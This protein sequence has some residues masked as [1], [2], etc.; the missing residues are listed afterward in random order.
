MANV[1]KIKKGLDINLVGRAPKVDVSTTM[2]SSFGV[3]PDDFHGIVPRL[4]VKVGDRVLAGSPVIYHK[5]IPELVLTSPV[6][7]EVVEVVRGAK[8]KIIAVEIKADQ[9]IEY[10]DFDVTGVTNRTREELLSLLLESGLFAL[11]KQRPYDIVADPTVMP[12]DIFV[13]ANYTAPLMPDAL[14]LIA[15]D[16]K[17]LQLAADVLRKL[18]SGGVYLGIK[19]GADLSLNGVNTYEVEGPHPA[20]NVGVLINHTRPINKGETV[21]T[22]SVSEMALIGRF[23]ATGKVDYRRRIVLAGSRLSTPGYTNVISGARI[24]DI[25]K[26]KL[27]SNPSNK[28]IIDGDV[29]TGTQVT[30]DHEYLSP[31]SNIITVIPEGDDVDELFGWAVPGFNKFSASRTYPSFLCKKREYNIDAR[32]RGGER[33]IIVSGEY[34]KVF[35]MDIYPEQLIK[36]IIAFDID[37]MEELGIYEVAPEDFALCEFVCT[38]KLELQYIV[39]RGLDLLYKEMN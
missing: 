18:T 35:P 6:S 16:K 29:L 36:S 31:F 17:Y 21:W 15:E 7:G 3:V 9:A 38:S 19:K 27:D 28:R 24:A 30:P 10:R 11:I 20:G 8:R 2:G 23:L 25:I 5:A 4:S 34:E 1:I 39:R 12:R 26:D 33:A 14:E 37:R 13:T 32:I 22:L